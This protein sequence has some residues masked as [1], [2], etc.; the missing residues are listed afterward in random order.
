MQLSLIFFFIMVMGLMFAVTAFFSIYYVLSQAMFVP[1]R[2]K[3][4]FFQ[5]SIEETYRAHGIKNKHTIDVLIDKLILK[6]SSFMDLSK[7]EKKI[8]HAGLRQYPSL[9]KVITSGLLFSIGSICASLAFQIIMPINNPFFSVLPYFM[10]P[11][12]F[13]LPFQQIESAIAKK[14]KE[15][16]LEAPEVLDLI[17][18]GVGA[19]LIFV[20]ALKESRPQN[21]GGMDI[22][23]K[24]VIAE[25]EISGDNVKA[26]SKMNQKINDEKIREF[27]QQLS[28]AADSDKD[29]QIEICGELAKNV[30]ELDYEAKSIQIEKI[31]SF[32]QLLQYSCTI[33]ISAVFLAFVLYDAFMA[34][35]KINF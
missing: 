11:M 18:Q 6:I 1:R 34:F 8:E 16:K 35:S 2:T 7:I 5:K 32:L 13:I 30:R 22:L 24:D 33:V 20:E 19:G 29:R 12:G 17:R 31:K 21:N 4:I 10:A 9:K 23:L 3:K 28:V 27:L 15:I 14:D 26:I 25:I